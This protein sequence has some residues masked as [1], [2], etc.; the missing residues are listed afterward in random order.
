MKFRLYREYG[1]LNSV[2]VFD[3]FEQG[4]RSSGHQITKG[5]DGIPV[6]WSVLWQGRML[7]NQQIY[8]NALAKNKPIVIIEVGNLKRGTTWRIS[9]NNINNLGIFSNNIDLDPS[10]P[11]KLGIKLLPNNK[12]RRS[13]ILITAQHEK[14]LQWNNQPKMSAWVNGKISEIR[15]YTN[16]NIVVRPHPRSPLG[17]IISDAKVW[18][19]IKIQN[20]YDDFDIDYNYHCVI[21]YNSGPAVQ[22]AIR[23]VP[24]I[25]DTSSLAAELSGTIENIENILLPDREDWFLKLCHT[26]WLVDEIAKGIPLKRLEPSIE[27]LLKNSS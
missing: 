17:G 11:S 13:D 27:N 15:R 20:S 6:I 3:A 7:G 9:L 18:Q 24:I 26:E 5:D 22:A 10:R 12:T 16:R 25:C 1:A 4:I 23:G 19:P 21:N 2:S 14:S 8:L